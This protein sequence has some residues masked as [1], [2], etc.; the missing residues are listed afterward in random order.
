MRKLTSLLI[1][2][3]LIAGIAQGQTKNVRGRITDEGGSPVPF[4]TVAIKGTR[5]AVVSDA[6]G[7]FAVRSKTGD[8]LV[9]T[10]QGYAAK[11][12]TIAN[13]EVIS[14]SLTVNNKSLEEV[15]VTGAYNTKRSARSTSYSAQVVQGEQLNVIRQTNLNNALAG[16][17]AGLQVRSQ[18]AA[19][20]G[21][22]GTIR[23]RGTSGLSGDQDIIYV[24]DGTILP[25]PNDINLDDIENVTVLQ[26]PAAAAQFGSQGANGAIVITTRRA[27]K[28]AR[29]IGIDLNLGAQVDRVY[30]LPHYQ[31]SYA[32]GNSAD[33]I[34]YEWQPGQ[35][36]EWKALNG[37]YYHNYSDDASWGPRMVG[38]EYIPWYAWYGGTQYAYKTAS[39]NS[40]PDNAR[41]FWNTA[42]TLNNT[43]SI[44]KATDNINLRFSYGNV[45]AKGLIPNSS[46]KKHTLN[47]V[48]AIDLNQHFTATA[49]INY[50]NQVL[51][52]EFDQGYANQT[53]GSFN[54]WFHRD[55]D[56][57]IMKQLRGLKTPSGIYASWNH[58]DP[59]V[60]GS[61]AD[62]LAFL[63]GNYWYNFYTY[64]DL[65]HPVTQ[66][67]RLYGDVS[68]T[69]KV[70]RDLRIKATYR[71]QQNNTW[72]ETIYESALE[73]SATQTGVKAY[74]GTS[75]SYSNRRNMELAASYSKKFG[76]FQVDATVGS[77]FFKWV[78][79]S[80]SAATIDG[81][82]VPGLYTLG[83]SKTPSTPSNS[84]STEKYT[85][86]YALGNLGFKN[87]VFADFTLRN[88][89]YSTLP[90]DNNRVLSKSFG[91]S[92]VFSDLLK[93]LPFLSFGKLRASWGEVPQA[94]GTSTTTFGAYR[95]PGA[96]Y[97][98][99]N[100]WYDPITKT[101]MTTMGT[102]DQL[103]DS[104]IHG[105]VKQMKE[106]GIE[107]R[108]LNNRI[109]TTVAYWD[110]TEKDI[111][112][113]VT[114]NGA[115]GYT[116]LLTNSG[117]I[118][119]KGIDITLNVKPIW[120]EN[121]KWEI[122]ASYAYLLENEVVK[123]S[124]QSTATNSVSTIWNATTTPYVLHVEGKQWGQ[125]Y[126]SAIKRLDGKPIL[127]SD[128]SY[129]SEL[130]YFGSVLPKYTG[131]V[132]NSFEIYKNFLLNINIDYQAGGKFFSLSDMW[133]AYSGLTAR[134]ATV[135]DKGFS[136][137]D[138]VS[139]GGGVHVTGVDEAGH[140][141]DMYVHSQ[142][143]Y[144]GLYSHATYDEFVYDLTFIKLREVSLGYQ[145]PL[146]GNAK[147]YITSALVSLVA[148]N[149]ILIYARTK[150]LDPSEV[151]YI[152]GEQGQLPGTRGVGLNLK[153]RF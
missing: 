92:F 103:V 15:V 47:F 2:L 30:V 25:N 12:V 96:S 111:P 50:V 10:A 105:A 146:K 120:W 87:M 144:Q 51:S 65:T 126:G 131:G 152:A 73:T 141:K 130:K 98:P 7:A 77:D 13:E 83:N 74:Y 139:A 100:P 125:L 44:T 134:T 85:A 93:D 117:K 4:A 86:L 79:K 19:L 109:G 63:G 107:L 37:K 39:L 123:I 88:D 106:I 147:K 149:P 89:W 41:D 29:G 116:S 38:Q 66:T 99:G 3:L 49:N 71:K 45:D 127:N 101:Y 24:V 55:L 32:G 132:Q 82:S 78:S 90:K 56:M 68:L 69:Y 140:P 94:L 5:S 136:V 23:L 138:P 28:G 113:S 11:E 8:V 84:R 33:L 118:T 110:G 54:S 9:I 42:T 35:P 151:S 75:S 17:V 153:L 129:Q 128:G 67:D 150:D 148:R 6:Q 143:Y 95:Y 52:G 62:E 21:N 104:S 46:L 70:N 80:Y 97:S 43:I 115:S 53:S 64:Y 145:I 124:D 58:N 57:K 34:K 31:N 114:I 121:L 102:P 14:V 142:N 108:F 27:K 18:S 26:G 40:Q 59:T 60:Y 48:T 76:D 16:K 36:E 119:K 112:T 20:L 133:G 22:T 137:R 72:G 122:N 91:A 81:L 135:N 1:A 61:E